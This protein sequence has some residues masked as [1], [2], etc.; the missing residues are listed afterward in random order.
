MRE[1]LGRLHFPSYTFYILRHER[2]HQES[3]LVLGRDK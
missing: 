3:D 2:T 1:I